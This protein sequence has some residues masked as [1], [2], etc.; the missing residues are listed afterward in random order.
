MIGLVVKLSVDVVSDVDT[1]VEEIAVVDILLVEPMLVIGEEV[2]D[3]LG[4][5]SL[6]VVKVIVVVG[7]SVK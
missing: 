3:S 1:D 5:V 2:V 7:N 6:I 4:E